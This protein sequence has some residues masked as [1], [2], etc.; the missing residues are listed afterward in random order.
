MDKVKI[1]SE[2]AYEVDSVSFSYSAASSRVLNGLS[3]K[4]RAEGGATFLLGGNGSGKSTLIRLMLSELTP[5]M[6]VIRLFG[7][8]VREYAPRVRARLVSYVPQGFSMPFNYTALD[9][10]TMGRNPHSSVF[11]A[12]TERDYMIGRECMERLSIGRLAGRGFLEISG[13]E[14]KLCLIARALAQGACVMLMDEPEAELDYGNRLLVLQAVRS[15]ANDGTRILLTSHNP[16]S[17]LMFADETIAIKDGRL[18]ASGPPS[19]IIDETLM[20]TLYG[21]KASILN[22]PDGHRL[23]VSR[24]I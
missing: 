14:K 23:M 11:S 7:R 8:D 6:G 15:L 24:L 17:A 9:V 20:Q 18:I 22:T 12:L 10:V 3:L 19:D 2:F 21:V 13:G 16:E 1:G 5:D 4:L